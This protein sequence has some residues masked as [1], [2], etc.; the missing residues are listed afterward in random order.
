VGR[1]PE[2]GEATPE[3]APSLTPEG[4]LNTQTYKVAA[5]KV[6]GVKDNINI[7]FPYFL[8]VSLPVWE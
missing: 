7:Y 4:V 5:V 1:K 3:S 2:G 6:V 8:A